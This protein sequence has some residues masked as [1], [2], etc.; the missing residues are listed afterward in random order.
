MSGA[1][2]GAGEG[3]RAPFDLL[4]AHCH[5]DFMADAR[6]VAQ[7]ALERRIG[8]MSMT[9]TPAAYEPTA[10][11]LAPF[12]NV[13]VG[14][15]LHPWWMAGAA[16][17]GR[18]DHLLGLIE[19]VRVVGEVG[20]DFGPRCDVAAD[21]QVAA[22]ERI[23]STCARQGGKVLSIHAVRSAGTVLDILEATGCAAACT[24]VLH[25]FSGTSDELAR[26]VRAGCLFS[27]GERMLASRRGRAYVRSLLLSRLLLETDAP[28]TAPAPTEAD[29]AP[30]RFEHVAYDAAALAGSLDAARAG[31]M[32]ERREPPEQVAA[33]LSATAAA[34]FDV[35]AG[36]AADRP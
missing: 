16:A 25:W 15:G 9:A 28:P 3:S 14:A 33:A 20:L 22:F 8:I 27:V 30:A 24:C 31:V 12:P 2:S 19:Q 5:L 4:D 1:A 7:G 18:F 32:R 23:A 35:A 21:E 26:A 29:V 36:T 10:Q 6:R 34:L 17:D 11:L 13:V